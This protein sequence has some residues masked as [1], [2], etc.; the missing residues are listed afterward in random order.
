MWLFLVEAE[1]TNSDLLQSLRTAD[2][3]RQNLNLPLAW[4]QLHNSRH[5]HPVG[6]RHCCPCMSYVSIPD[7]CQPE[8]G[9]HARAGFMKTPTSTKAAGLLLKGHTCAHHQLQHRGKDDY[10]ALA[11]AVW[12]PFWHLQ[13]QVLQEGCTCDGDKSGIPS[14]SN[15]H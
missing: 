6:H 14:H 3:V 12:R 10:I 7:A 1:K 5:R 13:W 11:Y 15:G 4:A 2:F 8:I 9:Q